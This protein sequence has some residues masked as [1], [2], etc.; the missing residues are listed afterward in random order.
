MSLDVLSSNQGA[1]NQESNLKASSFTDNNGAQ[2]Q[3]GSV[4]E[5]GLGDPSQSVKD[6]LAYSHGAKN[7]KIGNVGWGA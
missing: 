3:S 4:N 6:D 1:Y 7:S 2:S 5:H